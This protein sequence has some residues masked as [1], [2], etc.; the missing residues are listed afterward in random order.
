MKSVVQLNESTTDRQSNNLPLLM[1]STQCQI[2]DNLMSPIH[3]QVVLHVTCHRKP[4]SIVNTNVMCITIQLVYEKL[5]LMTQDY[6][7]GESLFR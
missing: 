2:S 5:R 6:S 7:T 3:L 1:N 4:E